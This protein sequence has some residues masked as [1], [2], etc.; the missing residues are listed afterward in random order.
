MDPAMKI[1]T[2]SNFVS[3]IAMMLILVVEM[4]IFAVVSNV[5]S[6]KTHL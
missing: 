4:T 5:A 6:L 2:G 1:L 3:A